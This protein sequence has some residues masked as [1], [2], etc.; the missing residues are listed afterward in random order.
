MRLALDTNILVYA[1]GVNGAARKDAATDLVARLPAA[2]TFIA[3]QVFGELYNVLVRKAGWQRQF[4][5]MAILSWQ[6]SY[7]VLP[8]SPTAMTAAVD[9][10]VDHQL[11][12]WDAL[13]VAVAAEAGCRLLL[14]EDLQD[15]FTWRGLSV[16]NP[17]APSRHPLLESI[18]ATR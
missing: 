8:T 12:I 15:G 6:D 16:T 13:I 1:E 9:L 2:E 10:A 11:G 18:L 5:R 3:A 14:S 4:A 17:F 7:D